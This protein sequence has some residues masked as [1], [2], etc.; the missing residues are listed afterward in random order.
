MTLTE[1]LRG[2]RQCDE[3]GT[4]II[5]SRE[6]CWRAAEEIEKLHK[7]GE[8]LIYADERG[9]GL[10]WQEAVRELSKALGPETGEAISISELV[11]CADRVFTNLAKHCP[12]KDQTDCGHPDIDFSSMLCCP[13]NCPLLGPHLT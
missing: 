9:Q 5:M 2:G 4:E 11:K 1:V 13:S 7:I 12:H 3:D 6:A 10:P 8:A